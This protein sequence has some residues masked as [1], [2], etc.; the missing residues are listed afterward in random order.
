MY[1]DYQNV[2]V[3]FNQLCT[4]YCGKSYLL[5]TCVTQPLPPFVSPLPARPNRLAKQRKWRSTSAGGG[6]SEICWVQII[7]ITGVLSVIVLPSALQMDTR[8]GQWSAL[9]IS[10]NW[11][12]L[13][14]EF[15][16][17]WKQKLLCQ[18]STFTCN[19]I[20]VLFCFNQVSSFLRSY[21]GI[22]S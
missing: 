12:K 8:S 1:S 5:F 19:H 18:K 6:L 11:L 3:L 21:L 9:K 16:Q 20:I 17:W 4:G 7:M 10:Q 13:W 14:W 2:P 15:F 22:F